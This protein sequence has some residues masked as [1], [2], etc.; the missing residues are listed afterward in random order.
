MSKGDFKDS[1]NNSKEEVSIRNI[2]K[3]YN[4]EITEKA[5]MLL[6]VLSLIFIFSCAGTLQKT[7]ENKNTFTFTNISD[8]LPQKGLWRQNLALIDMNGDGFPDIVAPPTRKA[9]KDEN[10]PCIFLWDNAAGKWQAG[11]YKFPDSKEYGYG[12]VAAGDLNNDGYPDI[13]LAVHT[14]KIVL[15][16]NNKEKGFIE[17]PF[18]SG[19]FKSRAVIATDINGDGL[20]DII[21]LSEIFANEK[22]AKIT[23][24][25]GGILVG[26]NKGGQG[27]EAKV[28][29]GSEGVF[30]DSLAVGDINGDGNKD[31]VIATLTTDNEFKKLV[32][33]GDGKGNFTKYDYNIVG[34]MLPVFVRTGDINGDGKDEIV[35]YLSGIGEASKS[36]LTVLSWTEKGFEDLSHQLLDLKDVATVFDLADID[37]DGK[38]ELIA[39]MP[40]GIRI[41]KFTGSGWINTGFYPVTQNDAIGVYDME[42][43]G[44]KDGSF[45]AVYNLGN[46]GEAFH[47]GLRAYRF[48]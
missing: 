23:D 32:W 4:R 19:D 22:E 40:D 20:P 43:S 31:I 9:E 8:G 42:V 41:F 44:N 11:G 33:F 29:D 28:I 34:D 24:R 48:R 46:E 35:F 6:T 45:I 12:S 18:P 25:K 39:L 17:Q 37:R 36:V 38:K 16:Y 27:W 30:G 15:L 13:V 14:G 47:N 3:Y 21:A 10:R 5:C 7:Q 2:M 1:Y 26:L